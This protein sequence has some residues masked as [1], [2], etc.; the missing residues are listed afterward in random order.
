MPVP[1]RP[2]RL[3]VDGALGVTDGARGQIVTRCRPSPRRPGRPGW[4]FA[5]MAPPVR[6]GLFG[7]S[8]PL[9]VLLTTASRVL[10]WAFPELSAVLTWLTVVGAGQI[11]RKPIKKAPQPHRVAGGNRV[12]VHVFVKVHASL[13]P[14]GSGC[15]KCPTAGLY[16][17]FRIK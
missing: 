15:V 4:T 8:P 11:P 16:D 17:R 6:A 9:L 14:A 1:A 12:V 2:R 10:C 5:P 7:R 3:N 13:E